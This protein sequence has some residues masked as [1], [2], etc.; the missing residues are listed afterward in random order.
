MGQ[1]TRRLLIIA[2]AVVLLSLLAVP[3]GVILYGASAAIAGLF[4]I[5]VLIVLQLPVFLLLRRWGPQRSSDFEEDAD[6]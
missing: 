1:M 4:V 3:L 6:D 5:G 2:I